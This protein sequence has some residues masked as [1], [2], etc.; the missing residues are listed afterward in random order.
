M[1]LIDENHA[2]LTEDSRQFWENEYQNT[3]ILINDLDMI[4]HGLSHDQRKSYQMNTGQD[5]V[6]VTK[7]DLPSL[8]NS[9]K[10]LRK[11]LEELEAKL[12]IGESSPILTQAVPKW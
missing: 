3:K 8:I 9:R 7:Q 5:V 2:A 6:N 12:G 10:Q 4:I 11:E 1:A